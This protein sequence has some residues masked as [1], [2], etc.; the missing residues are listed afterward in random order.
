LPQ[1]VSSDYGS[2]YYWVKVDSDIW[3]STTT[4]GEVPIAIIETALYGYGTLHVTILDTAYSKFS[5]GIA[6]DPFGVLN[7][8][9]GGLVGCKSDIF[10]ILHSFAGRCWN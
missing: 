2:P 1:I 4:Y 9:Q 5:I 6:L 10:D 3:P 8:K 7:L